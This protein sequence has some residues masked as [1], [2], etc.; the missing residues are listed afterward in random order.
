MPYV[1]HKN[2]IAEYCKQ[3]PVCSPI[4]ASV[5]QFP[6]RSVE[7]YTFGSEVAT[8]RVMCKRLDP[9]AEPFQPCAGRAGIVPPDVAACLPQIGFSLRRDDDAVS[10]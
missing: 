2:C 1:Q 7:R 10:P 4:A 6:D 8:F 9:L 3:N 5:E